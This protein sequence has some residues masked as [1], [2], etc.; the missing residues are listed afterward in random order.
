[1]FDFADLLFFFLQGYVVDARIDEFME[2]YT[3]RSGSGEKRT[4]DGNEIFPFDFD[5]ERATN[6][7]IPFGAV[8]LADG[9]EDSDER[10]FHTAQVMGEHKDGR[11]KVY[12]LNDGSFGYVKSNEVTPMP[13]GVFSSSEDAKLFAS[14]DEFYEV[15]ADNHSEHTLQRQ[16]GDG[17]IT[18]I[19]WPQ[20]DSEITTLIATYDGQIHMDFNVYSSA[21]IFESNYKHSLVSRLSEE[22][23]EGTETKQTDFHPRGHG[24]V[25]NFRHD[26]MT[27]PYFGTK[28][29]RSI[30]EVIDDS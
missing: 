24:R 14:C 22:E 19:S 12:F 1:M 17:C 15:L 29:P 23:F 21:D 25:V 4:V 2:E 28:Y 20:E 13:F 8:V 7:T 27:R 10:Y 26:L 9:L 5:D 6:T 3:V 18:V 30:A 16:I 11:Y